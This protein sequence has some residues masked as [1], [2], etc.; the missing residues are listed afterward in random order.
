MKPFRVAGWLCALA[1]WAADGGAL[2]A[3]WCN[4][5]QVCCGHCRRP[6]VA[7][8]Y[9]ASPCCPPCCPPPCP[10]P[11]CTT[12]YSLRCYYQPV[13]TFTTRTYYEPVTTYRTSYYFEPVTSC[14]YKCVFDPCTC[15][16]HQVA[17]PITSYVMRSQCCPVQS[18][19]QRCCQ[20]PVTTYQK[21]CYWEPCTTCCTPT[22]CCNPA[23]A[24]AP[25]PDAGVAAPPVNGAPPMV[26]GAAPPPG[27][28]PPAPPVVDEQRGP[29]APRPPAVREDPGADAGREYDRYYGPS[30]YRQL[31]AAPRTVQP[32]PPVRLDK[33]VAAPATRLEGQVVRTDNAPRP[34]VRLRFVSASRGG[35]QYPVEA[36][37]AGRFR[38]TLTSGSWLVYINRPDGRL[39]Y[40]CKID[41]NGEG[42]RRVTLVSR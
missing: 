16:Y 39:A 10:P 37:S 15:C 5:F 3:A 29:A 7:G 20:V 36:N 40:H 31:P 33:I 34:N 42:T 21:S 14:S 27:Y 9:A 8:F 35:P 19:V 13:T 11:V 12:R 18:W 1:L 6:V 41:V 32:P 25:C 30:R 2:R 26:N 22:P 38:V 28:R 24:A 23:P 4:V 17:V